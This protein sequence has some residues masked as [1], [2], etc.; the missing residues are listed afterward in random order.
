MHPHLRL[1]LTTQEARLVLA[2]CVALLGITLVGA[3]GA[4]ERYVVSAAREVQM[5]GTDLMPRQD[6]APIYQQS[7]PGKLAPVSPRILDQVHGT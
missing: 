2:L 7:D 1:A 3:A 4:A 5:F 6:P